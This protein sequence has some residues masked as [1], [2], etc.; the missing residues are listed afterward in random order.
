MKERTWCNYECHHENYKDYQFRATLPLVEALA[1][2]GIVQRVKEKCDTEIKVALNA[3]D[4]YL[5]KK[6]LISELLQEAF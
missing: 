4:Q 2:Q 6:Y 1:A 3:N 5:P